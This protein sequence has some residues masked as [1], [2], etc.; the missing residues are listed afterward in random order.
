[1]VALLVRFERSGWIS[2]GLL[3]S[4][5]IAAAEPDRMMKTA[6]VLSKATANSAFVVQERHGNPQLRLWTRQE[7]AT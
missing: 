7:S 4:Q 6:N 2:E 3:T 5:A 1:L